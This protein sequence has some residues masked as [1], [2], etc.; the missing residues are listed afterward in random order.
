L[1]KLSSHPPTVDSSHPQTVEIAVVR[2]STTKPVFLDGSGRRR[3]L[4]KVLGIFVATAVVATLAV[5]VLGVTG[6]SPFGIPV[7]PE[8]H[9]ADVEST[10]TPRPQPAVTPPPAAGP[11]QPAPVV[12]TTTKATPARTSATPTPSKTTASP[13]ATPT[14]TETTASP[15]PTPSQS[16]S[17]S[18]TASAPAG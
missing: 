4:V 5:L 12:V 16:A 8:L 11:V 6:A 3:G 9:R 13:T 15:T 10:A 14:P 1:I 2:E 7:L 17:A 18:P